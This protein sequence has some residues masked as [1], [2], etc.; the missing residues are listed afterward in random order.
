MAFRKLQMSIWLHWF[1]LFRDF[2]QKVNE[3][4]H[5]PN[6][7]VQIQSP[8]CL[9][10]YEYYC[11][12]IDNEQVLLHHAHSIDG[13]SYLSESNINKLESELSMS[14]AFFEDGILKNTFD[15]NVE[16]KSI[17]TLHNCRENIENTFKEHAFSLHPSSVYDEEQYKKMAKTCVTEYQKMIN[18]VN[19]IWNLGCKRLHNAIHDS[20]SVQNFIN[21]QSPF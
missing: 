12:V 20:E 7:R 8:V 15:L 14:L 19:T 9:N 5:N 1:P 6:L 21:E 3:Q 4:E 10:Q 16:P 2:V 17:Q 18:V 13:T 11:P